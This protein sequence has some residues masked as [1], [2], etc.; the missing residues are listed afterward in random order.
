MH[1]QDQQQP[2]PPYPQVHSAPPPVVVVHQQTRVAA[3]PVVLVNHAVDS[4][5]PSFLRHPY[6]RRGAKFSNGCQCGGPQIM[7][8]LMMGIFLMFIGFVN[9]ILRMYYGI[10]LLVIGGVLVAFGVHFLRTAKAQFNSLPPDHPDRVKY[11]V[12]YVLVSPGLLQGQGDQS[13]YSY[14]L[15]PMQHQVM[16][17]PSPADG[18]FVYYPAQPGGLGQAL[19]QPAANAPPPPGI[20][21]GPTLPSAGAGPGYSPSLHG[22]YVPENDLP[23]AYS[24]VVKDK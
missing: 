7:V 21:G 22:S 20:Y 11:A 17:Y 5:Q 8:L 4:R 6:F 14:T 13:G 19:P 12:P 18:Q 2:P 15:P 24:D 1:T 10:F 9:C 23:P 3:S 16:A